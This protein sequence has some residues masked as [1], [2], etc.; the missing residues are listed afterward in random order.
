MGK[1]TLEV[2][3]DTLN[4]AIEREDLRRRLYCG[5]SPATRGSYISFQAGFAWDLA[6]AFD[7]SGCIQCGDI[8]QFQRKLLRLDNAH[9]DLQLVHER[10]ALLRF[11][12]LLFAASSPDSCPRSLSIDIIEVDIFADEM[13]IRLTADSQR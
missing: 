7:L 12:F 11:L 3:S 6:T 2:V 1:A 13:L 9:L 10:T 8:S 5:V 4:H